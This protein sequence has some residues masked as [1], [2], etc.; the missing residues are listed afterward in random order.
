MAAH[1]EAGE[2]GEKWA[3]EHLRE[4]GYE[5]LDTNWRFGKAEIDIIARTGHYLC[6]VEVKLR[7]NN[8]AGEPYQFVGR[9]KQQLLI[10]AA[11]RYIRRF[12]AEKDEA[13]FDVVSIIH[14]NEYTRI[15][16]LEN[17]FYPML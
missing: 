12:G 16:H 9:Q 4:K 17:A 11:D 15:E 3:L 1:N 2:K 5:I 8:W 7:A 6:F 10:R 13:R 14:N